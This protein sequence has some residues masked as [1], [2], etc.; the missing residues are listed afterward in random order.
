MN[1]QQQGSAVPY[2]PQAFPPQQQQQ[3]GVAYPPSAMMG[4]PGMAY[5]GDAAGYTG[6]G[7]AMQ[8]T[9][10]LMTDPYAKPQFAGAYPPGAYPQGQ[11]QQQQQYAPAMAMGA[12]M[13]AAA[14]AAAPMAGSGLAQQQGGEDLYS[15]A[16][17]Y[18]LSREEADGALAAYAEMNGMDR[19]A[20]SSFGLGHVQKM[21]G[22]VFGGGHGHHGHDDSHA[23]SLAGALSGALASGRVPPFKD[24]L[25]MLGAYKLVLTLCVSCRVVSCRKCVV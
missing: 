20:L 16:Q 6:T 13:A 23:H 2:P 3:G 8:Q 1:Q 25:G 11:T 22:N 14:A 4:A 10:G 21:L 12:P 19:G 24:F 18:G 5:G 15:V 9:P 7:M 17:Q